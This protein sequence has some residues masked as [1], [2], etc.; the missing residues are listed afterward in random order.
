MLASST[1]PGTGRS[2]SL[3]TILVSLMTEHVQ[4]QQFKEQKGNVYDT[5]NHDGGSRPLDILPLV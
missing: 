5:G 3:S 1:Y 2:F 4:L